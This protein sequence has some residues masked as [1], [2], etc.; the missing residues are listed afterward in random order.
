VL[1]VLP[2]FRSFSASGLLMGHCGCVAPCLAF[3]SSQGRMQRV[4]RPKQPLFPAPSFQYPNLKL[5]IER[6]HWLL[7]FPCHYFRLFETNPCLGP[8]PPLSDAREAPTT[9]RRSTRGIGAIIARPNQYSPLLY[10][11]GVTRR[12]PAQALDRYPLI[13]VR[14]PLKPAI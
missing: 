7:N 2:F 8:L 4:V 14:D 13:L 1:D 6:I 3:Q 9:P 12:N 5:M 10:N 11:S